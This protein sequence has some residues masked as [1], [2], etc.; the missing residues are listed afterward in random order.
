M[1]VDQT[2][3]SQS[4]QTLQQL[5]QAQQALQRKQQQ[6]QQ[7][8]Q[9]QGQDRVT[10]QSRKQAGTEQPAESGAAAPQ[11]SEA[12]N[13]RQAVAAY[14]NANRVARQTSGPERQKQKMISEMV[15]R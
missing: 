4:I 8:S 3:P 9:T 10:I 15:G 13:R 14:E 7:T 6:A 2:S 1:A 12:V 5:M 11:R